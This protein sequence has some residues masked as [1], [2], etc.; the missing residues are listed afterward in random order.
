[1]TGTVDPFIIGDRRLAGGGGAAPIAV[2]AALT[3]VHE[4]FPEERY[5]RDYCDVFNPKDFFKR[6]I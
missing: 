1:M 3:E 2:R 6:R 4:A 5:V